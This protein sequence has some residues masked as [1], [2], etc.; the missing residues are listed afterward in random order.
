MLVFPGSQTASG[1]RM[2]AQT[3]QN[4]TE[5][6][7]IAIARDVPEVQVAAATNRSAAQ[8]V[9][10]NTNW[11]T[12]IF[13]INNDYLEARDWP[14]VVG[15]TFEAAE[16]ARSGKVAIIGQTVM[17]QLFGD[18]AQPIDVLDQS[19]RIRKIPVIIIGVLKKKVKTH[20]DR[21]RMTW[22]WCLSVLCATES[23]ANQLED[24]SAL[25]PLA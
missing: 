12:S 1:V 19:V 17:K 7:A 18:S 2:G 11:S 6:D 22:Q 16:M 15:R 4:L 25:V 23:A 10:G 8:M 14:L 24:S 5:D 3:G 9:Y 21:I 13:G 20:L